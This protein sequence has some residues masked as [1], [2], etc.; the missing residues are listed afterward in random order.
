MF[1]FE[2]NMIM[3]DEM[4]I[5]SYSEFLKGDI[6]LCITIFI[7]ER[8]IK[9][10]FIYFIIIPL[11]LSLTHGRTRFRSVVLYFGS[12]VFFPMAPSQA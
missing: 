6:F 11:S 10:L 12:R 9:T 3:Y 4:V 1:S 2:I 5:P 7:Y 8:F